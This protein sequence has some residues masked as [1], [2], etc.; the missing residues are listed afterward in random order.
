MPLAAALKRWA[1]SASALPLITST[2]G[3]PERQARMRCELRVDLPVE[4]GSG[5]G[6]AT[7]TNR[8]SRLRF[9]LRTSGTVTL[10]PAG[11]FLFELPLRAFRTSSIS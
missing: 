3:F 9:T 2:F 5:A 7:R 6:T 11:W 10:L 4:K 1:T 8:H